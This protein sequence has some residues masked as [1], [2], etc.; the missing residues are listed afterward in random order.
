V[1]RARKVKPEPFRVQCGWPDFV[2][3]PTVFPRNLASTS[4]K[5]RLK[6]E[7][8]IADTFGQQILG[9]NLSKR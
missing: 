1:K 2:K 9:W 7:G 4:L 6:D 8:I 5:R 3:F